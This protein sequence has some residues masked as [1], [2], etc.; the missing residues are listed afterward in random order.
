MVAEGTV[1]TQMDD[2]M[3]TPEI[4]HL[5]SLAA[6]DLL[7][8]LACTDWNDPRYVS[9][10]QLVQLLQSARTAANA[11]RV[12]LYSNEL[13]RRMLLRS[14]TFA[15]K[16]GLV[17]QHFSDIEDAAQELA[18][19]VWERLLKTKNM[20]FAARRF[21]VF[22]KRQS[23]SFLRAVIA[24]NR[25]KTESLEDWHQV[26]HTETE[27][28]SDSGSDDMDATLLAELT[29]ER[30]FDHSRGMNEIHARVRSILSRNEYSVY[31]M[32]W[33][34]EMKVKDIAA[35]LGVTP[36]MINHHT[37]SI[38]DKINKEFNV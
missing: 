22:F 12:G 5:D 16:N 37:R 10:E 11:A 6:P 3:D 1:L 30:A 31:V 23:I 19:Y 36:R 20:A 18:G 32:L 27:D 8:R 9:E 21:G 17:P 34:K 38:K 4:E 14:Q 33:R 24:K 29:P 13:S 28:E 25:L 35:A 15:H 7:A 26:G 2:T